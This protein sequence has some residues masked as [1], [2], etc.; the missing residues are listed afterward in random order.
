MQGYVG[1][2]VPRDRQNFAKYIDDFETCS[3]RSGKIMPRIM[4]EKMDVC[5]VR[6][7]GSIDITLSHPAIYMRLTAYLYASIQTANCINEAHAQ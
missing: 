4:L 5:T 7:V 1:K 2:I 6:G 3:P